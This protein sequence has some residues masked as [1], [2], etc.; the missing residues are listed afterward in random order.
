[1]SHNKFIILGALCVSTF[2]QGAASKKK[3]LDCFDRKTVDA[4]GQ[5]LFYEIASVEE[6]KVDFFDEP[7]LNIRAGIISGPNEEFVKAVAKQAT[8]MRLRRPNCRSD[9][10][11]SD[12]FLKAVIRRVIGDDASQIAVAKQ[13]SI[14]IIG[15]QC[16]G[17]EPF[18]IFAPRE[19]RSY[20]E[21]L[22]YCAGSDSTPSG[23]FEMLQKYMA[24]VAANSVTSHQVPVLIPNEQAFKEYARSLRQ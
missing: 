8:A 7:K 19:L 1:M 5:R 16:P 9:D 6:E 17:R 21:D 12:A 20:I 22:D 18:D 10:S 15:C 14:E 4:P 23:R 13:T 11:D 3:F 24:Q 2:V